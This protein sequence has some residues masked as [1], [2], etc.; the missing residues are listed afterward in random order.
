MKIIYD[1]GANNGDELSYYLLKSD[2]VVAVEAN[3]ALCDLIHSRFSSEIEAGRLTVENYVITAEGE[4]GLI[5]FYIH[6]S[7]HVLSQLPLPS[8]SKVANSE[9]V[10]LPSKTVS[11]IMAIYGGPHYIK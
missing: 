5:D 4:G 2:L 8:P 1:F 3:P 9:K 11:E 6:K 7:N 10:I